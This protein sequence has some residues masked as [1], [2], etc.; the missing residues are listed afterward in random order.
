M[1]FTT[2]AGDGDVVTNHIVMGVDAEIECAA[3]ALQTAGRVVVRVDDI[4]RLC[5][6][7]VRR[8][9]GK[10]AF[11]IVVGPRSQVLTVAGDR[12]SNCSSKEAESKERSLH[13]SFE[14]VQYYKLR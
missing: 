5:D 1:I 7:V 6:N 11:L 8:G 9:K 14:D 10:R 3:A 12:R 4:L 2:E 13:V